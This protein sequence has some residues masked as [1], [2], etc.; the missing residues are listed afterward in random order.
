[1]DPDNW[2]ERTHLHMPVNWTACRFANQL[3]SGAAPFARA[4]DVAS[5][6][7][8]QDAFEHMYRYRFSHGGA[9]W[10]QN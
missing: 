3:I 7:V 4:D 8:F 9:L 6:A 1:M 10:H 5:L 2:V